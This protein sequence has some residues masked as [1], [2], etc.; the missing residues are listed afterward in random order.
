MS[1]T[2]HKESGA[3]AFGTAGAVRRPAGARPDPVRV[4]GSTYRLQLN[5]GFNLRQAEACIE[6]L[7]RLGITDCYLSPVL[8]ARPGSMHGYDIT[9]H[10]S[11]NPELGTEAD[12]RR[13]TGRLRDRGMGLLLDIVPNHM[14]ISDESNRWWWQVLEDGPASPYA[15]FFDIDW[16]PPKE[17]LVNKILLPF[18]GDQYGRV[19]EGQG[20]RIVFEEGTFYLHARGMRFPILPGSWRHILEPALAGLSTPAGPGSPDVLELQSI[21][22]ALAYLPRSTDSD[23]GRVAERQR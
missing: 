5:P 20:M 10:S 1:F 11:L 17:D 13:F 2:S 15:G 19:L 23:P 16:N 9:D 21:L 14:C 6:Y 18:L 4:P 7:G 22:T 8:R 12:W 3:P